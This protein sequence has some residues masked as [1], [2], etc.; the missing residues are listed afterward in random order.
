HRPADVKR[1]VADAVAEAQ[2]GPGQRTSPSQDA[3]RP[4]ESALD[5]ADGTKRE[6]AADRSPAPGSVEPLDASRERFSSSSVSPGSMASASTPGN[7]PVDSFSRGWELM[8][9]GDF[10]EA[11]TAFAGH[12]RRAGAEKFTIAIGLYCERGNVR[13]AIE[14]SGESRDLFILPAKLQDRS[15]YRVCWG[16]FD[17]AAA[18]R[19]SMASLPPAILLPDSTPVSVS[20]LMP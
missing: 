19:R 10:P 13:R 20:R 14:S 8:E 3:G 11:A 18:G 2:E 17:S 9:R 12:L 1:Q 7:G 15:C 6:R 4:S 5:P 16:L